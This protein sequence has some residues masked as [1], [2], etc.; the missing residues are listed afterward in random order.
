MMLRPGVNR[1]PLILSRRS[2]VSGRVVDA[3]SGKPLEGVTIKLDTFDR[4]EYDTDLSMLLA[5]AGELDRGSSGADGKFSFEIAPH[6]SQSAVLPVFFGSGLLQRKGEGS[7]RMTEARRRAAER[8]KRNRDFRPSVVVSHDEL[9]S[10]E[11]Q[12]SSIFKGI[13]HMFVADGQ[14]GIFG[15]PTLAIVVEASV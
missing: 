10:L 5:D 4:R 8:G 1:L 2:T 11:L 6:M 15:P 14:F 12:A 13:A 3:R 7:R 9:Q